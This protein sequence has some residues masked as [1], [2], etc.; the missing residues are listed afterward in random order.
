MTDSEK[1]TKY[2]EKHQR[3]HKQLAQLR[4]IFLTTELT[5]EIKW[6]AP[7]Y[8]LNGKLVAGMAA[9][10]NHYAL[11]FHQ[12]VF[13][14]D[15]H[16]QLMNAQKGTTKAMRQWRFDAN[17]PLPE[18]W[19]LE[20]LEEAV[21]NSKDG[22]EHKPERKKLVIPAELQT[23][24]QK[25]NELKTAYQ[26]LTPGKQREYA[27]HISSAKQEATKQRRLDK[28]IPMIKS[29]VGLHDKYKNC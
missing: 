9:F 2:I 25:H 10:K 16:Q 18:A 23:A 20:Y 13:L 3:W 19:V 7:N 28:I 26:E 17:T 6:G 5:E 29:G 24:L 14:K 4:R 12:G 22:K 27:D 1:V 21:Q 15:P 8:T 11:W